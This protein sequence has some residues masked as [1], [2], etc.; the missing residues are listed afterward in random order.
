MVLFKDHRQGF[1]EV[2]NLTCRILNSIIDSDTIPFPAS[3][4]SK[5]D[6]LSQPITESFSNDPSVVA[7]YHMV[8]GSLL[9]EG[10]DKHYAYHHPPEHVNQ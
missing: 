7:H 5:Q 4:V 8:H 1:I 9:P 10:D 2:H 3:S 6:C